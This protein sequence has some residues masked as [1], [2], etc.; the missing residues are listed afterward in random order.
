MLWWGHPFS[1]LHVLWLTPPKLEGRDSQASCLSMGAQAS[2]PLLSCD[3]ALYKF[4]LQL[5]TR[6]LVSLY[7]LPAAL[8]AVGLSAVRVSTLLPVLIP[9]K[10]RQGSLWASPMPASR[11]PNKAREPFPMGWAPAF[12]ASSLRLQ[13][14]PLS[15]PW[16][17]LP[18]T[19]FPLCSILSPLK[20]W[21]SSQDLQSLP[22]N[23]SF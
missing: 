7:M 10:S 9:T 19:H 12:R 18:G 4:S 15:P 16:P 11:S 13:P 17:V 2:N 22:A 20:T 21:P 5:P 8:S 3:T 14:F 23:S 6:F 1:P